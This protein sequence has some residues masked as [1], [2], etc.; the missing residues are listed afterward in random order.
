M[1]YANNRHQFYIRPEWVHA[2]SGCVAGCCSAL[3][4]CPLEL[5]KTRLIVCFIRKKRILI[6]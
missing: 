5:I 6:I 4:L 3:L 1:K 2:I